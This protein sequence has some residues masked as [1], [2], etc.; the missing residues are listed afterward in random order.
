[1]KRSKPLRKKSPNL[2]NKLWKLFSEYIRRRNADENGMAP[3]VTCG[4]VKHWKELQSGHY[5]SKSKGLAVYFDPR[6]NNP[7][8]VSCNVFRDGNLD[9]YALY[10]I[11]KYGEGILKEL[12]DL[13][14]T[15]IKISKAEYLDLISE[16]EMKLK[17]MGD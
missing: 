6:N 15:T 16:Y 8:C 10:M 5:V 14:R 12:D 11:K 1:M 2:K 7:Q 13:R 4:V 3:C 9:Q 17:E